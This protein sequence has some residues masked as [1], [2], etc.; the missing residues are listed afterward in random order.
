MLFRMEAVEPRPGD[1]V[2][3][4]GD[5]SDLGP[6]W[7]AVAL[8]AAGV[9][10]KWISGALCLIF[11]VI[12]PFSLYGSGYVFSRGF[13]TGWMVVVF[14]WSWAAALLIWVLPV[15]ESR[16]QLYSV[17]S[18]VIRRRKETVLESEVVEVPEEKPK[19]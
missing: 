14:L 18:G 12:I 1:I 15:W 7:D 9:R 17:V 19:V 2:R 8:K 5:E 4:Q 16:S 13:F 6:E 11:L 10:A 3:Q